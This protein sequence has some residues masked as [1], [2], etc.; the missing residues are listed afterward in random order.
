MSTAPPGRPTLAPDQ[1]S[2]VSFREVTR[3]AAGADLT[4][5]TLA[6]TARWLDDDCR[7]TGRSIFSASALP[8]ESPVRTRKGL[9]V[10]GLQRICVRWLA[11]LD[12]F[13]HWLIRY[14]VAHPPWVK[15][16]RTSSSG[17]PGA[18]NTPS[19]DRFSMATG[20][21]HVALLVIYTSE[22]GPDRQTEVES[23]P[24]ESARRSS[25]IRIF[26]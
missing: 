26:A 9:A 24:A 10:R 25:P 6:P 8:R 11:A 5:P 7:C 3:S 4:P 18:S 17:R 14:A 12:D 19:S 20:F 16:P 21:A 15:P 2:R 23:R 22:E 1:E 13:R